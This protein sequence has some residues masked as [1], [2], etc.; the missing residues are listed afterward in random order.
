MDFHGRVIRL[1]SLGSLQYWTEGVY[2]VTLLKSFPLGVAYLGVV[3]LSPLWIRTFPPIGGLR[4]LMIAY[5][6]LCAILSAYSVFYAGVALVEGWPHSLFDLTLDTRAQHALH[7]Y[8]L[9]KKIELMDTVFMIL[10][11]KTRQMSFLHV[12]H[13]FSMLLASEFGYTNGPWPAVGFVLG[14]NSV[15]HVLLYYYYA[16]TALSPGQ[17]P[18]WKKTLTVL[19]LVQFYIGLVHQVVGYFYYGFCY[20]AIFYELTMIALF[21]HFYYLAYIKPKKGSTKKME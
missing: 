1:R 4:K 6:L 7:V 8:W 9:T 13:H 10:R 21:S 18:L 12:Y 15:I 20:Y 5:N 3:F 19:Q 2:N 11:H 17:R 16:L 14:M